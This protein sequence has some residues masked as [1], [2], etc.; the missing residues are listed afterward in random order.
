M[1]LDEFKAQVRACFDD[2]ERKWEHSVT[3]V[4]RI[5]TILHYR[6]DTGYWGE[7]QIPEGQKW[8]TITVTTPYVTAA[9]VREQFKR[10]ILPRR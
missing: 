4:W 3:R 9:A 2:R 6:P 10:A 1:N 8:T 5:R 7:I